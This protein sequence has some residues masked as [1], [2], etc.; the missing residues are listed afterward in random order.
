MIYLF[1]VGQHSP[2]GAS[3]DHRGE[4]RKSPVLDE[5]TVLSRIAPDLMADIDRRA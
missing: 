4:R 3:Y 5:M 1:S 2:S